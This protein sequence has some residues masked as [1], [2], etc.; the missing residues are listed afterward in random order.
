M[1]E[2]WLRLSGAGGTVKTDRSEKRNVLWKQDDFVH[3]VPKIQAISS[4]A[5]E[6][7]RQCNFHVDMIKMFMTKINNQ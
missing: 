2:S 5:H 1:L 7:G 3:G 6:N 4:T